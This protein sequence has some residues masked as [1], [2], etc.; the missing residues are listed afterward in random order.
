MCGSG[1]QEPQ[2]VRPARRRQER[3]RHGQGRIRDLQGHA[4]GRARR[5]HVGQRH[6]DVPARAG[7]RG[8]GHARLF[9]RSVQLV[10][11]RQQREQER[12]DPPPSAQGN[13]FRGSH[14]GRARRDR[15][16]DQRHPH[17]TPRIQNAQRG[18]GRGDV[19]ATIKGNQHE[20]GRCTYK[21]N[22]GLV[23]Q[24]VTC[25]IGSQAPP[26]YVLSY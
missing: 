16:G 9:R 5:P 25:R 13:H 8:P 2:A 11:A 21:L 14:A 20:D 3:V 12:Q 17:E 26:G 23:T 7:G 10:P 4:A 1:A 15:R 6:G 24:L 19:Q 22:P 18:M